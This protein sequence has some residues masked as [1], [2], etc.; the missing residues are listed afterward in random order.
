MLIAIVCAL[1]WCL[2]KRLAIQIG[3]NYLCA[4]LLVQSLKIT[5]RIPRPWVLD[6]DFKAVES[7]MP[8]ATGYSFPSGHTQSGTSLFA[9]LA[10]NAK[11]WYWKCLFVLAFLLIGFSR[12]YLGCHTPKD[13]VVSMAL[14]LILCLLLWKYLDKITENPKMTGTVTVLIL[15]GTLFLCVQSTILYKNGTIEAKYVSDCFKASGAALGF[16]ISWFLENTNLRFSPREG[17]PST[18]ELIFRYLIGLFA[19]LILK[20]VL[21]MLLGSSLIGEMIQYGL[22]IFWIIYVYPWLFTKK[23]RK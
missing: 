21:K 16:A 17:N 11:K 7:A 19:A 9:P 3:F 10:L 8:A 15:L 20:I 13:V 12:M 22:L 18:K 14:S 6:P 1:Y 2:D 23:Y 4:G 5:V